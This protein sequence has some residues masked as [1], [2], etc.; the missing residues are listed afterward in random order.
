MLQKIKA[1]NTGCEVIMLTG[2]NSKL[3]AEKAKEHGACDFI[4]KPFDIVDLR[5]KVAGAFER[6]AK[7]SLAA[8]SS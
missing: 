6:V 8:P 1:I 4:G 2:V 3:L 7:R 5:A